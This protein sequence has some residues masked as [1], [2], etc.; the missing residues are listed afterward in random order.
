M[1]NLTRSIY[2]V[3]LYNFGSTE[4][5]LRYNERVLNDTT[6]AIDFGYVGLLFQAVFRVNHKVQL[7]PYKNEAINQWYFEAEKFYNTS[8]FIEILE[9]MDHVSEQFGGRQGEIFLRPQFSPTCTK[10]IK[11][12]ITTLR[13][14]NSYLHEYVVAINS[15]NEYYHRDEN[16]KFLWTRF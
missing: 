2:D 4:R 11:G 9:I 8:Y 10:N 16:L 12:A 15:T 1:L 3:T 14:A 5:I 7:V 13:L 6:Y